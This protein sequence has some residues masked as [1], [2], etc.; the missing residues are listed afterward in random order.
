MVFAL[1]G[2]LVV[3]IF[4]LTVLKS[5]LDFYYLNLDT[6]LKIIS[7]SMITWLP[8]Y[9]ITLIRRCCYPETHEKLNS[10]NK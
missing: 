10:I 9:L 2:T 6:I 1:L 5:V 8:F 7:I 4:S 3:Y